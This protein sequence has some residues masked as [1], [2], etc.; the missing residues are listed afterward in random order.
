M[1][2]SACPACGGNGFQGTSVVMLQDGQFYERHTG[3]CEECGSPREFVFRMPTELELRLGAAD[4]GGPE[5]SELLD[6]GEWMTVAEV[7]ADR[8][9]GAT[10]ADLE[11]AAAAAEEVLKFLPPGSDVADA[12]PASAFHS[13]VGRDAYARMPERYTRG[14]LMAIARALREAAEAPYDDPP[15]PA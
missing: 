11:Y 5:P 12:I 1:D 4:F 6:P 9:A 7:S 2:I 15:G 13:P 3:P 14:R 10:K 8:D